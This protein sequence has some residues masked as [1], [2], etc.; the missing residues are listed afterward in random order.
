MKIIFRIPLLIIFLFTSLT[1]I[2]AATVTWL[3]ASASWDD[4]TQWDTGTVPSAGDDVIIPS[5]R[6]KI[7]NG[8]AMSAT[9][10]EVQASGR[11]Y[12]YNGGSLEISGAVDNDGLYNLGRCY[13][14]G[15]LSIN[16]IT[17]T[18]AAISAKAIRN[19]KYFYTYSQC[20]IDITDI[21]DLAVENAVSNAYFRV[22]G[23]LNIDQV[24]TV[25]I[26]NAERFYNYGTI[27]ITNAGTSAG[28]L[29]LNTDD[30]R[31]F[32]SGVINL[33]A[34]CYG[35][36]SNGGTS[37]ILRNYGNINI[38]QTAIGINNNGGAQ[39]LNYDGAAINMDSNGTGLWNRV[40]GNITNDGFISVMDTYNGMQNWGELVNNNYFTVYYANVGINNYAGASIV[41]NAYIYVLSDLS[42]DINNHGSI[43]SNNGAHIALNKTLNT[44]A[45]SSF[46]NYGFF[47][48]YGTDTHTINGSF[49]TK[50]VIDDNHGQLVSLVSNDGVI[51]AP[52]SGTMQV[53][54]P[55]PNVLNLGT[56]DNVNVID[57][58]VSQ[59]GAIA[60][61]YNE[62]T[63]TFT[64]NASA[65]G[66]STIFIEIYDIASGVGRN[67]SLELDN[68]VAPFTSRENQSSTRN[69]QDSDI[70]DIQSTEVNIFPNPTSGNIQIESPAFENNQSQVHIFNNLGQLVQQENLDIGLKTQSLDFSDQL[71]NG[72]YFVKIIQEGREIDIKRIQL[73]R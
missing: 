30:F 33:D 15:A 19:N 2:D 26:Y 22:R 13:I 60:G 72:I 39:I 53:G 51:V 17:Q 73:H 71:T 62:S 24:N 36:I 5:G 54:V 35:G 14:Y 46:T 11:L 3:G 44:S 25:A 64:P 43:L 55:F 31:N 49:G 23:E 8:D 34:N 47:V 29:L 21:D 48:L 12:V 6:C 42:V 69:G 58:K 18:S 56:L 27:N 41:N 45:G 52:V 20:Q 32:S 16:N 4:A 28:Y 57:W 70:T 37:P 40:N 10:V 63:N 9:S 65:V 61:T 7:Y 67:F 59:N 38:E 1:S 68:P 66:I 50:G